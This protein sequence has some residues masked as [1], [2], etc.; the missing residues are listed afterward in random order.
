MTLAG[1]PLPRHMRQGETHARWNRDGQHG[2]TTLND[3][4][5]SR[6]TLQLIAVVTWDPIEI[7]SE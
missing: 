1:N 5:N 2:G 7:E 4:P 6:G 3:S